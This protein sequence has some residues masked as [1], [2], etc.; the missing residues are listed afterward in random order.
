VD[1]LKE[2]AMSHVTSKDGTRIGYD[3]QGEGAPV[4]L[5]GGA[6]QYRAFDPRTQELAKLLAESFTVYSYDRRAGA[7]AVTPSRMRSGVR[8]RTS[9][10]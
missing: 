2:T 10:R 3:R 7:R 1:D 6:F 5:V 9:R 8:S 4:V